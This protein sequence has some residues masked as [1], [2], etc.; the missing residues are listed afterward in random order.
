MSPLADKRVLAV[1]DEEIMLKMYREYF[2]QQGVAL[3]IS[4]SAAETIELL[5]KQ[6]FDILIMDLKLG[7]ASGKDVLTRIRGQYPGLRYV[8]V[9]AY[10]TAD[11]V[12]D[13]R[14]LGVF[15]VIKKPCTIRTIFETV[16]KVALSST[17]QPIITGQ[18]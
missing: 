18:D 3:S 17:D 5:K 15:E 8:F 13:L 4:S 16:E 11:L 10:A 1:D 12:T 7:D 9:T 14:Q 2:A 6:P